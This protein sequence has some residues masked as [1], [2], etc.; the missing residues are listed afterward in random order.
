MNLSDRITAIRADLLAPVPRLKSALQ[1]L[2]ALEQAL[3][4][5][6]TPRPADVTAKPAPQVGTARVEEKPAAK[7]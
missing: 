4:K 3:P 5:A 1:Q 2:D 7:P 6:A